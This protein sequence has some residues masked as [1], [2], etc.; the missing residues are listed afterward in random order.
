MVSRPLIGLSGQ[1]HRGNEIAGNLDVLAESPL[2]VYYADYSQAVIAAGAVPVFLP[3]D[4]DPSWIVDRL[5]GLLMTGGSDIAPARYGQ[6]AQ[7]TTQPSDLVRD[8]YELALLDLAVSRSLPT[9]GICRGMQI[10]NVHA[11]GTLSQHVPSHA[12]LNLAP[13]T[14]SHMVS[15]EAG[16]ICERLFGRSKSV[17]SL[18]HQAVDRVADRFSA[19]AVAD[20]GVAEAIEHIDLPFLA[21]QWHPEMMPTSAT[22]PLF[23][24]LVDSAR[25]TQAA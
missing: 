8:A 10:M 4:I 15:I 7:A 20:D 5:D 16:S 2:D 22:D 13:T 1:R 11:G 17:N 6:T 18:H 24:W 12:I 21:V 9:L 19:T 23:T 14:E 3:L 25:I